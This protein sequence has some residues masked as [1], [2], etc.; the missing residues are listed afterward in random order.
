[1]E[2]TEDINMAVTTKQE[3]KG[4]LD[5]VWNEHAFMTSDGRVL[6][7]LRE[8]GDE[9]KT[10]QDETYNY[11]ANGEKNDF[12]NWVQ[13]VVKD[14]ALANSLRKAPNREQAVKAVISRIVTLTKRL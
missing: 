8:L 11:H 2:K 9:L 12:A 1:M 14:T 13:D 7:N 6:R 10:M 3:A 4:F 5:D